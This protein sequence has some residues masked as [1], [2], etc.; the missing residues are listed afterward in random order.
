M[1]KKIISIVLIVALVMCAAGCGGS[2]DD[3]KQPENE[4]AGDS[5]YS[6][7][8]S[9]TTD[10]NENPLNVADIFKN[11]KITMVNIWATWCPPCIRELPELEKINNELKEKG[12]EIVGIIY[13]GYEEG[14]LDNAKAILSQTGATYTMIMPTDDLLM[15]FPL[16]A[17]PTSYFVDSNGK[18][19]GEP[20]VGAY[21][22]KYKET[23]DELLGER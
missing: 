10:M 7:I 16:S 23:I 22:D 4:Q 18:I 8:S 20:V 5:S 3:V 17:F 19:V 1:I 11:N 2:K 9:D 15:E 21:V 12:C 6:G 14:A 13:D